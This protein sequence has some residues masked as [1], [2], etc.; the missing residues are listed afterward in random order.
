[1]GLVA[2][3]MPLVLPLRARV[4]VVQSSRRWRGVASKSMKQVEV[5]DTQWIPEG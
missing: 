2:I 5:Q 3:A 4:I 1:M